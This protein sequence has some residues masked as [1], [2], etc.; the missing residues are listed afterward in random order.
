MLDKQLFKALLAHLDDT[1]FCAYDL[2]KLSEE[3]AADYKELVVLASERFSPS[4]RL[5][6]L[7]W[8]LSQ[9]VQEAEESLDAFADALIHLANLGYPKLPQPYKLN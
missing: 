4:T 9:G 6:K 5:Q 3:T 7:W 8:H 2:L 1:V